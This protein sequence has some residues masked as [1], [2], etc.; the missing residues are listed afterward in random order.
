MKQERRSLRLEPKFF[1]MQISGDT[2]SFNFELPPGSYA[3]AVLHELIAPQV[4]NLS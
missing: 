1:Q 4:H 2:V 3:T